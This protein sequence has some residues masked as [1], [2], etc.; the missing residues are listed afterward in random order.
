MLLEDGRGEG[1][2][3]GRVAAA[4]DE[5]FVGVA[6]GRIVLAA[7]RLIRVGWIGAAAEGFDAPQ[8]AIAQDAPSTPTATRSEISGER[9]IWQR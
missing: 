9:R 4:A 8:P 6:I 5:G 1:I 3:R 2:G 7:E